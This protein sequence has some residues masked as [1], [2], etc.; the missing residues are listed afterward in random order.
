M[1]SNFDNPSLWRLTTNAGLRYKMLDME[2]GVEDE[3]GYVNIRLLIQSSSLLAFFAEFLPPPITVG[4]ISVPQGSILPGFPTL[5]VKKITFKSFDGQDKPIDPFGF[6]IG[7]PAGTYSPVVEV[8]VN[9]DSNVKKSSPTSSDPQ[10]FLEI[11]SV[12]K[13]EF[14]HTTAPNAKWL[15]RKNPD[16]PNPDDDQTPGAWAD[17]QTSR[18]VSPTPVDQP[19]EENRDPTAP[20][21]IAVPLTEWRVRWP[22]VPYDLFSNVMIHRLRMMHG[23]VNDANMPLLFYATPE[24]ILFTGYSQQ[25]RHTWRD[26]F[27][28]TPPLSV[29]MTFL[30]KRVVWGGVIRGHNDFWRPGKGWETLLI[31]GVNKAHKSWNLNLLFSV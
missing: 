22:Q 10:T 16:L 30:E 8:N 20:V 28:S 17:A 25:Q 21:T 12:S 6:D 2:G 31:D 5:P 27:T 29:E 11:S 19:T 7:A 13:M 14:M 4:N 24:T 1:A 3:H 23:R 18:I 26:G 9:Y 15:P